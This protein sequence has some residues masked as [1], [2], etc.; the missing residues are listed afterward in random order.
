MENL[1]LTDYIFLFITFVSTIFGFAR[2]FVR[3][4]FTILNLTLAI[5]AATLLA[6]IAAKFFAQHLKDPMWVQGAAWV[7]SYIL[8]WVVIAVVNSFVIDALK[9]IRGGFIDRIMGIAL[10]LAR[11]ALIVVGIYLGVVITVNA[12]HDESRLPS[13]LAEAKTLNYIKVQST[14]VMTMM[15]KEYQDFYKNQNTTISTALF[16][17]GQDIVDTAETPKLSEMGFDAPQ[18]QT[19]QDLLSNVDGSLKVEDMNSFNPETIKMLGEQ[20]IEDYERDIKS[21]VT[22]NE[23]TGGLGGA[24]SSAKQLTEEQIQ[25]LKDQLSKIKVKDAW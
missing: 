23:I 7:G 17:A 10:G 24:K 19:L 6:P 20:A 25:S 18:I 21:G 11:G 5:I 3:E 2:G 15:P 9:F 1:I 22:S 16:D 14:Y 4:I 12:Q 8:C 13:W